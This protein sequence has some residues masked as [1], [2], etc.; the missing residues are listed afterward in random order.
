MD[1]IEDVDKYQVEPSKL[2]ASAERDSLIFEN[3]FNFDRFDLFSIH[4]SG[5]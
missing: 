5:L 1:E 2:K 3:D 4:I